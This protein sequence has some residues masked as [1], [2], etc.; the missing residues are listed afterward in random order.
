[1]ASILN[2]DCFPVSASCRDVTHNS[3]LN[4]SVKYWNVPTPHISL[5]RELNKLSNGVL[6]ST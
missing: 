2:F 3:N 5:E 6:H 4:K 1:M